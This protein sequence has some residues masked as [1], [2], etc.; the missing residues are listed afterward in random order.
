MLAVQLLILFGFPLD[1]AVPALAPRGEPLAIS[2]RETPDG[3]TST[4][5]IVHRNLTGKPLTVRP[6]WGCGG[7]RYDELLFDGG[8]VV[9]DDEPEN[10]DDNYLV[11]IVLP[12]GGEFTTIFHP[13]FF[14]GDHTLR[15][16]FTVVDDNAKVLRKIS[17]PTLTVHHWW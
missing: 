16:T 17:S 1:A 9:P 10:C 4:V 2:I 7:V 12:P 11:T 8:R 6:R 15:A 3:R 5:A 13:P 14:P